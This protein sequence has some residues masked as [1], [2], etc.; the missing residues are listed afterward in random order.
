MSSYS[1][2][3][4]AEGY[5]Y[6]GPA[7]VLTFSPKVQPRDFRGFFTV[8]DGWG[9]YAQTRTRG[10]QT[11]SVTLAY[12]KL[13]LRELRLGLPTA[14]AATPLKVTVTLRDQVLEAPVSAADGLALIQF[15][16]GL[17]LAAT[18]RLEVRLSW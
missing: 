13:H 14:R 3:I 8:A 5:R 10:A 11:A 4:A 9:T 18:D 7:G 12:G 6:D 1:L 16:S 15:P 17:D 2:L